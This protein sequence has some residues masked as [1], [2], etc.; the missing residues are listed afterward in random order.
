MFEAV[1]MDRL[2]DALRHS[3]RTF[4][5]TGAGMSAESGLPTFRGACGYWRERRFEDLASPAGF[6][7]NPELV[8][9]WYNE[10]LAAYAGATPNA[11][12]VALAELER[13]LTQLTLATQNVDSL[14]QRAGSKNV[15]ELHGDLREARCSGCGERR[16]I[17][18]S[19]PLDAIDHSC[20]GK[21]RPQRCVVR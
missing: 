10:R 1:A 11:G 13:R 15:L 14:H 20:G 12:H 7:K 6:A 16:A 4:V 2:L 5:L 8:W 18:S 19:F 3:E 17:A 21:F 9:E